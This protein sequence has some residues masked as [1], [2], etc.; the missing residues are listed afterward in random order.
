MTE[1]P[2][3]GTEAVLGALTPALAT[4]YLGA[5]PE[6]RELVWKL[7]GGED[8]GLPFVGVEH[9]AAIQE[10]N[11]DRDH[12]Q[13]TTHSELVRRKAAIAAQQILEAEAAG[14]VG[15]RIRE[16]LYTAAQLDQIPPVEYLAPSLLAKDS[17]AW[18]YGDPGCYKSFAALDIAAC[19]ALGCGIQWAGIPTVAVPVLY[20][21]AEGSG[22]IRKRVRA[23]EAMTGKALGDRITYLTMAPPITEEPYLKAVLDVCAQVQPGLVIIDTQSRVTPGL[24]ENGSVMG[25]YVAAVDQIRQATQA[26]VMT[27]HHT[28]KGTETLRGHGSLYGAAD[29]VLFMSRTAADERYAKI[30][31]KKQKDDD[32]SL[33]WNVGL[34]VQ[35]FCGLPPGVDHD[36]RE[37]SSLV[38]NA[39]HWADVISAQTT[40]F[41]KV[42]LMV[43][44]LETDKVVT[45]QNIVDLTG[46][47]DASVKRHLRTLAEQKIIT[48]TGAGHDIAYFRPSQTLDDAPGHSGSPSEPQ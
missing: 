28:T 42:R 46:V 32:D 23:W 30:M 31:I 40:S 13:R 41:E 12:L 48:K 2:D 35:H 5:E 44:D 22:G 34:R 24:D 47:S 45:K 15:T 29:T 16:S 26:C 14:D 9:V 17:L 18:L 39:A 3:Q 1:T 19:V 21:A 20:I 8:S 25:L 43:M 37:C 27:L 10:I 38:I 11:R 4:A 33:F 36:G 7:L 6:L